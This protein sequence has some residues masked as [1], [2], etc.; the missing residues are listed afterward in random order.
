MV[1]GSTYE[2]KKAGRRSTIRLVQSSLK[3]AWNSAFHVG[4][5][6]VG[7]RVPSFRQTGVSFRLYLALA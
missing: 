6:C 3:T 7:T 1:H 2:M 4:S 5:L